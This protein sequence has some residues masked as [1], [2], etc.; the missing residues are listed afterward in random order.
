VGWLVGSLIQYN[1]WR[2][3]H[4]LK[5]YENDLKAATQTFADVSGELSKVITLQ[6]ILVFNYDDAISP[7]TD[8]SRLQFLW[9]QA[10][11]AADDYRRAQIA[12]RESIDTLIRRAEIYIDWPSTDQRGR[13]FHGSL[14]DPLTITKLESNNIDCDKLVAP[15]DDVT[16]WSRQSDSKISGATL[17]DWGSAK[18][19]VTVIYVCFRIDH[20]NFESIRRWAAD[21]GQTPP[22]FIEPAELSKTELVERLKK[23]FNLQLER[24]DKFMVLAMARIDAIRRKN[25]PPGYFCHLTGWRCGDYQPASSR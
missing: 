4:D 5:R 21:T 13:T 14:L 6:Q 3:E 16:G 25:E 12:L 2:G 17:V 23:R 1:S 7:K 9:R 10:G 20:R 24:L 18:H 15:G 8:N 11:F 19:H 22:K